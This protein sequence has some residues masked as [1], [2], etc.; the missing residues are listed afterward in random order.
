MSRD[1]LKKKGDKIRSNNPKSQHNSAYELKNSNPDL[2][3]NQP[4]EEKKRPRNKSK[5]N[6]RE[7]EKRP[8]IQL[9]HL[10]ARESTGDS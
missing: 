6:E 2:L 8:I 10:A 5:D 3:S 7:R 9:A 4:L 1:C